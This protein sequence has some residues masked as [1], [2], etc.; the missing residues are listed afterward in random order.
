MKPSRAAAW[1]LPALLAAC[2][3]AEPPPLALSARELA[4]PAGADSGEPF[5]SAAGDTVFMSWL[6]RSAS[7]RRQMR[8]ARLLGSSWTDPVVITERERLL[9][10]VS[11][12]PSVVPG[13]DGSLWAHWL[14]RDSE[15]LGYGVRVTTSSDGGATWSEPWVPHQ[16]ATPTEHGFVSAVPVGD[17][18][19]ILWLDGRAFA[20]P[21]GSP[22]AMETALYF[23]G[24]DAGGATGPETPIDERVCDCCQTDAAVTSRGP[25]VAYRDRSPEEIRDIRLMRY[26]NG[27]WGESRLVH[28]DGWETGACPIN[29]PAVAARGADVVVAWFTAAAGQPKV[30]V[31]FSDDAADSFGDPVA[32]DDGNP[33]GRVDVTLLEDGSAVV[34]WVERTG[35]EGADVRVRR[36]APSGRRL[37]ALNVSAAVSERAMGFPRLATAGDGAIIVAWTDGADITAR[38]RVTRIE[39]ELEEP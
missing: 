39:L 30:N 24:A 26:E 14:E 2:G 38:V 28:E 36:V 22:A 20:A 32:V 16:D 6:G 12:F 3:G 31:A 9:V 7:G 33:A 19:G 27:A 35:G 11:D 29:G 23:R 37:E 18:M 13:P 34:S 4:S 10:N 15:G 1:L 17:G 8:F 5:V 25:V 21:D